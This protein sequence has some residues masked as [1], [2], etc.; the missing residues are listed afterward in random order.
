MLYP[1]GGRR[2]HDHRRGGRQRLCG[3][4][5]LRSYRGGGPERG[6][7]AGYHRAAGRLAPSSSLSRHAVSRVS[8]MGPIGGRSCSEGGYRMHGRLQA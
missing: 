3:S 8:R 4:D 7:A 6:R 1:P 2:G 5:N